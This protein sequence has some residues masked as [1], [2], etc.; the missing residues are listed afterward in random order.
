MIF[1]SRMA[2]G[3][4]VATAVSILTT[5]T[6][7]A[8]DWPQFRGP[9]LTGSSPEKE[10]FSSSGVGLEVAWRQQLGSGYSS[11][12]VVGDRAVTMFAGAD[13]DVVAAFDAISGDKLWEYR[14][15]SRYEG[16]SGSDGGPAGT[17]AIA[18][19]T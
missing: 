1:S 9:E 14:V 17:P 5:S 3:L 15:G 18:A 10:V 7:L 4:L 6:V 2:H 12:S 19:T 13:S 16:H 11:I 8:R